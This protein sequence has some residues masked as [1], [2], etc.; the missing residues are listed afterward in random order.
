MAEVRIIN[1]RI[2]D[3]FEAIVGGDLLGGTLKY[4]LLRESDEVKGKVIN[5]YHTKVAPEFSGYGIG[6]KLARTMIEFA[7]DEGYKILPT[8][9]FIESY[10]EKHPEYAALQIEFDN[11]NDDTESEV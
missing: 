1:N 9:P 3:Q 4:Q 8:C 7:K 5:A 6:S 10:L 11:V 2:D